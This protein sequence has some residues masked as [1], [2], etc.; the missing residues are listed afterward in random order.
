MNV[1]FSKYLSAVVVIILLMTA[2][3]CGDMHAILKESTFTSSSRLASGK[4]VRVE[5]T[6]TGMHYISDANLKQMGFASPEK[7]KVYGF[8]GRMLSEELSDGMPDDL[9]NAASMRV[10]GGL[11]FFATDAVRWSIGTRMTHTMN[12]YSDHS[13]YFLSDSENSWTLP[14]NDSPEKG[15]APIC[16]TFTECLLHEQE[17]SMP[18]HNGRDVFG[19]ELRNGQS[20]NISFNTPD[21][22]SDKTKIAIN[23]G[24]NVKGGSSSIIVTA[25][26]EQL[27][28]SNNDKLEGVTSSS[29]FLV[30]KTSL[31]DFQTDSEKLDLN[32][33]YSATG[34]FYG[35]WLDYVEVTY[36][37]KLKLRDGEL[38]FR[39]QATL[40]TNIKVS[41]CSGSTRIWDVTDPMNPK[42]VKYTLTGS[43]AVFSCEGKLLEFIAF[44]P[45]KIKRQ[46]INSI[47]IDNQDIQ[48][49][50]AHV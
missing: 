8:G 25:N 49:G 7:V 28:S 29:G 31:K 42:E 2:A 17:L 14:V 32:I 10:P 30:A 23:Y 5:A 37:R 9:P 41:G 44:E 19:E 27:P 22:V 39:I 40:P 18:G 47:P 50:R 15:D 6:A 24:A 20:R 4:W 38:F 26:G 34:T 43:D 11:V 1:N 48:I 46:T 3:T 35:A 12:P 33:K 13:Y 21:R 16:D 36:S 45:E